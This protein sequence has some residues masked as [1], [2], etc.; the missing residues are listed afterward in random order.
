MHKTT[1]RGVHRAPEHRL[2]RRMADTIRRR[3]GSLLRFWWELGAAGP[4]LGS[5]SAG[6]RPAATRRYL[7]PL[8]RTLAGALRGSAEHLAVYLDERTRYCDSTLELRRA[9]GTELP[10]LARMLAPDREHEALKVLEALHAPLLTSAPEGPRVLF[11]GDCLFVEI[12]AFVKAQFRQH[13]AVPEIEHVFF[14]VRQELA[15]FSGVTTETIREFKPDLIGL[16]LFTF[17]AV[18]LF[19]AGMQDNA[20]PLREGDHSVVPT[21]ISTLESELSAIRAETDATIVVHSPGGIPLD[22]IRRRLPSFFPAHSRAQRSFLGAVREGV[23][24][25][26]A[27]TANAILLDEHT[28]MEGRVREHGRPLFHPLQ[29]PEGY[30]HTTR[31]GPVLAEE[32]SHITRTVELLGGAKALFVDFDNTLWSGVMAEGPVQHNR[33]GQRLLRELKDAGVLLVALSKNDESAIRWEEMELQ[34]ED[35]VLSKINW[36]PKPDNVAQAI[37]ELDLAPTAF[38][39]LDDNPVE[40]SLVTETVAGVTAL[41]PGASRTWEQLR[42]WLELPSTKRTAEAA[43]RTA[44]YRQAAKRRSAVSGQHDYPTMM[45]SLNLRSTVRPAVTRDLERLLELVQRTNQFNTTTR[46]R[47]AAELQDLMAD[48]AHGVWVATLADRFGDLGTVAIGIFERAER[49]VESFIMSCRAMGFGLE[50]ALL[51]VMLTEESRTDS[52]PVRGL[53]RPTERN[54]PA[55]GLFRASGFEPGDDGQWHLADPG[56]CTPVPEWLAVSVE[57][58]R[59]R[60]GRR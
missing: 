4:T 26:V 55:S 24:E 37:V 2:R 57:P 43:N 58:V 44:M 32:Y 47:S 12:R 25:L 23:A 19:R 21:L 51:K 14:S 29:V 30:F 34:P 1:I 48:D 28:Q 6:L 39:L 56:R 60:E 46:R 54:R 53:F 31:L 16:S 10:R 36:A 33:S 50:T 40:R 35:F 17:D 20:H 59:K 3:E 13:H 38:V 7:L 45:R 52:G 22:R 11:V 42:L 9:L 5:P 49:T 8:A 18:P 27:A 15:D 41:D